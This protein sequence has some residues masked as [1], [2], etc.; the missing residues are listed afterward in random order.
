MLE[1]TAISPSSSSSFRTLKRDGDI[2]IFVS[3]KTFFVSP[4]RP[5]LLGETYVQTLSV[6]CRVIDFSFSSDKFFLFSELASS[7]DSFTNSSECPM[8]FE[9][10][11]ELLSSDAVELFFWLID[12]T[13]YNSKCNF[14]ETQ[15]LFAS[16]CGKLHCSWFDWERELSTCKLLSPVSGMLFSSVGREAS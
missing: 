8:I 3:T 2:W 7:C 16:A 6:S 13:V 1:S 5:D 9:N 14:P 11:F 4:K 15:S 10:V 12:S